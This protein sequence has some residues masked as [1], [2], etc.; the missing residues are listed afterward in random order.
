MLEVILYFA[1]NARTGAH[2]PL[3]PESCFCVASAG[4]LLMMGASEAGCLNLQQAKSAHG[5]LP[6]R[7]LRCNNGN[8]KAQRAAL[9][10]RLKEE[11]G[12]ER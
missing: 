1:R 9:E 8:S 12:Y 3:R 5:T 10:A 4:V 11:G 6:E 7:P 2:V